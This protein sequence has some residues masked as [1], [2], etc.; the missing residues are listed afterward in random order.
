MCLEVG[1]SWTWAHAWPATP[2][3]TC[4]AG[5]QAS[6]QVDGETAG[7]DLFTIKRTRSSK[8]SQTLQFTFGGVSQNRQT[9][10]ET[11]A[12]LGPCS[13]SPLARTLHLV[14]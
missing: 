3:T 2:L 10:T 1:A 12:D 8:T 7:G 9:S 6:V 14:C 11:Q 13:A 4:A 5:T